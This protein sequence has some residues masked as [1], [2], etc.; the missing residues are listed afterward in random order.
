[1]SLE[2]DEDT[3]VQDLGHTDGEIEAGGLNPPKVTRYLVTASHSLACGHCKDIPNVNFFPK[4]LK[5][6]IL[7]FQV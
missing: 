1:M 3:T 2:R 6:A 4:I 5:L 7:A